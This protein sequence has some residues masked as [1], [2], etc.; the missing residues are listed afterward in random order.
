VAASASEWAP[1]LLRIPRSNGLAKAAK[2]EEGK[3]GEVFGVARVFS[4]SS[5]NPNPFS[6]FATLARQWIGWLEPPEPR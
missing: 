4:E 5:Q 2:A 1:A 6:A 3:A